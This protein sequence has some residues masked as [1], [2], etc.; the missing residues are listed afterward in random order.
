MRRKLST[1]AGKAAYAQRKAIV[2]P[3]FGQIKE[4]SLEFRRFSFRG[5]KKVQLEWQLV[6]AAHNLSKIIRY[7]QDKQRFDTVSAP[8]QAA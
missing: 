7:R 4:A 6:C 8:R 5:L 3:A 1:K 2:E